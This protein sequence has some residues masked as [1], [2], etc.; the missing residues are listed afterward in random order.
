[1]A[2]P[3][4]IIGYLF[5]GVPML[6][7]RLI[8][9]KRNIF[10]L[11]MLGAL[12]APALIS[13][14]GVWLIWLYLFFMLLPI[15]WMT[16]AYK[17]GGGARGPLTMGTIGVTVVFLI[18]LLVLIKIYPHLFSDFSNQ[19]SQM[20][21]T[22]ASQT[23]GALTDSEIEQMVKL[24]LQMIP[25]YIVLMAMTIAAI[26]H[27]TTRLAFRRYGIALPE[28]M[29]ADEWRVP[30]SWVILYLVANLMSFFAK[31]SSSSFLSVAMLNLTPLLMA[32]FAIQAVGF[33][34]FLARYKKWAKATPVLSIVL[35]PILSQ[36][37]VLVGI[38]D[39]AFSIRE[40]IQKSE[41]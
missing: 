15:N 36:L 39:V 17:R 38:V 24:S 22:F 35:F 26:I 31:A 20:L 13:Y 16:N 1:M 27:S 14:H 8:H 2:T 12:A 21:K 32:A 4:A 34:N 7:L 37:V 9:V 10:S 30:R 11:A 5:V 23:N 3:F 29:I 28:L 6:F 25:A 41:G 19:I 40:R 33:L 18:I